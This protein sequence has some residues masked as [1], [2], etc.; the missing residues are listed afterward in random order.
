MS[1]DLRPINP[2]KAAAD[3]VNHINHHLHTCELPPLPATYS[4]ITSTKIRRLRPNEAVDKM[5]RAAG[6]EPAKFTAGSSTGMVGLDHARDVRLRRL[7]DEF[8]T[9]VKEVAPF[10]DIRIE[11]RHGEY[12]TWPTEKEES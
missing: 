7:I 6:R 9:A 5:L 12:E 10:N 2:E 1:D 3:L 11:L 8:L 4:Y